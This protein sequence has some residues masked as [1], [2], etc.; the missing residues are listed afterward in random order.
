VAAGGF[1]WVLLNTWRA[2]IAGVF[3]FIIFLV[4]YGLR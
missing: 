3:F 4:V 2:A 1:T